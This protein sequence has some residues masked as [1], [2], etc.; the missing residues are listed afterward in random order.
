MKMGQ[1]TNGLH[2]WGKKEQKFD[3]INTH[4]C[5]PLLFH[6]KKLGK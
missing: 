1:S 6:A 2:I 5:A 3:G 4:A